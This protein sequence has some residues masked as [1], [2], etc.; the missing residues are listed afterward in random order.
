[1]R[2]VIVTYDV[3]KKICEF[4]S[5]FS[6]NVIPRFKWVECMGY[7]FCKR[8]EDEYIV[9][10]AV[11]MI[12]GSDMYVQMGPN[13]LA[14]IEKLEN[15]RPELFL[16]GWF[17]THPGLSPFYSDTDVL[18]QSFY[19]QGN[20]DGLGIVFDLEMI[21]DDFIGFKI[22]RND[23]KIA[24]TYHE[25][26]FKLR[27]FTEENLAEALEHIKGITPWIVHNLAVK[28]GIISGELK[29]I[30][31]IDFPEVNEDELIKEAD[32]Y[33]YQS[34]QSNNNK[35]F[36]EAM[37]QMRISAELYERG[38]EYEMAVDSY[39]D[40]IRL[41]IKAN[42]SQIANFMFDKL[43]RILELGN[44]EDLPFFKG[45][46]LYTKGIVKNEEGNLAIAAELM[47]E[48]LKYL[49]SEEFYKESFEAA[50]SMAIYL[51]KMKSNREALSSY[52]EAKKIIQNFIEEDQN[53][54]DEEEDWSI[55]ITKLDKKINELNSINKNQ[56]LKRII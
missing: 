22:F 12:S 28:Y 55:I 50:N 39:L 29:S 11:G 48:A 21:T 32:N 33:Y 18:N 3:F 15:E 37:N 36:K 41:S 17:H 49:N 5:Q 51:E 38:K 43:D 24:T 10:D 35:N 42:Y 19:Q 40:V 8:L 25:V 34:E 54:N 44:I 20:E 6:S 16:G 47:K 31:D 56:G 1:M 13:E 23:S 46:I 2:E 14:A 4:S 52:E 7:L 30:D 53:D 45:K 27:G 9:S 26:K